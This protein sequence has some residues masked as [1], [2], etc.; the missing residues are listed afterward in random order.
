M[1]TVS[2]VINQFK[3]F[4]FVEHF[5]SV[6][7]EG[8]K[9]TQTKFNITSKYDVEDNVTIN[10]IYPISFRKPTYIICKPALYFLKVVC[11]LV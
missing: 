5:F 8:K 9:K 3:R 1:I 6:L 10:Q 11:Q 2:K 7:L 4:I